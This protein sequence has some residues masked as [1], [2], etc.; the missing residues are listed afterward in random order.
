MS[1]SQNKQSTA[2]TAKYCADR[3]Q[4]WLSELVLN[5]FQ[6]LFPD[7]GFRLDSHVIFFCALPQ[8]CQ[9]GEE[10]ISRSAQAYFEIGTGLRVTP[11][12]I[13]VSSS[14]TGELLSKTAAHL[15]DA[16]TEFRLRGDTCQ[17]NLV[18]DE[19]KRRKYEKH[20]KAARKK[21]IACTQGTE[22]V[23]QEKRKLYE[24]NAKLMADLAERKQQ[25]LELRARMY[26]DR[27]EGLDI[28]D[29]IMNHPDVIDDPAAKRVMG[30]LQREVTA[31]V[32]TVNA[33]P[34]L[35][36]DTLD[37]QSSTDEQSYSD[38]Q[39]SALLLDF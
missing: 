29:E 24:D 1:A 4:S 2:S 11:A 3:A 31:S 8:E 37:T 5:A 10:L 18:R 30:L 9:I 22:E 15:W 20:L 21:I 38:S 7:R 33:L 27:D 14:D 39:S 23:A 26:E 13:S 34:A 6:H 36:H 17:R 16:A 25:R 12:G 32:G 28:C 35:S 19:E